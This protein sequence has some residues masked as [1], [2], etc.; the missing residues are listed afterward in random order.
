MAVVDQQ[1]RLFGR[2]N[3]FDAIVAILVLWMVPIAYASYLLLR[4]PAPTLTSIEPSTIA[5]G[6]DMR[7]RVRGT[8]FAP[9][10]RVSV[11]N[12]QGKTFKFNDTTDA[13][14]DLFDTP[15][16]TYDVILYD[17]SQERDRIP[18]GLTILPSSLPEAKL[19][20]IGTLGNLTDTEAASLKA[21]TQI[22]GTGVI[23]QV[24]KLQ[25]QLQRVFVRPNNV[26]IP[27]PDSRM[28]PVVVRLSCFV[29]SAQGQPECVSD[30]S[31]QPAA[32]LFFDMFGRQIPFQIDHVRSIAPVVPVRVAV[33]F[34]GEPR[35][36][37]QIRAGDM[38]FGDIRNELGAT[39][40]IESVESGGGNTRDA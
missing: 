27:I 25:P 38:D 8:H 1:G 29:R 24:G 34:S 14:V 16:G 19:V 5:Y 17:N 36:L 4:A 21:G 6:P 23:E 37:S 35:V 26:E 18:N 13:D 12:K 7:V 32:L 40:R 30:Y 28:L 22:P 31:V 9:Y 3:L 33:R 11:G 39:A 15:P 10:L 2:I 20:A